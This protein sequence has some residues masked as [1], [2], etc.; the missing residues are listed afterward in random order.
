[1]SGLQQ[2]EAESFDKL[3]SLEYNNTNKAYIVGSKHRIINVK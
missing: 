2:V 3:V 1:M